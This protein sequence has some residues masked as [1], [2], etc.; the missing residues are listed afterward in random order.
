MQSC[1]SHP[2]PTPYTPPVLGECVLGSQDSWAGGGCG[3]AWRS[4]GS[5]G[6]GSRFLGPELRSRE[7]SGEKSGCSQ[8][9]LLGDRI[10]PTALAT[11]SEPPAPRQGAR[12][13]VLHTYVHSRQLRVPLP[14]V[15]VWGGGCWR[16][17]SG[18]KWLEPPVKVRRLEPVHFLGGRV[19]FPW[20]SRLLPAPSPSPPPIPQRHPPEQLPKAVR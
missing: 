14:S 11:C 1:A 9:Q 7:V 12:V 6:A 13:R 19:S 15:E 20:K 4:P 10:I 17:F 3:Q 16:R 2:S 5:G 18:F 8:K